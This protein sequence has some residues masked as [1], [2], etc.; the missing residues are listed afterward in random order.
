MAFANMFRIPFKE[1]TAER[2]ATAISTALAPETR[3]AANRLSQKIRSEV[4]LRGEAV[5]VRA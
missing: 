1:L 2:L 5:K 4:R 3:G